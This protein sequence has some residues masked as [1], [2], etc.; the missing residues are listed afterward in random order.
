VA[1][2]RSKILALEELAAVIAEH[3]AKSRRVVQCHGIFDLIH[4]GHVRHF[5]QAKREGDVLVVT[6]TPDRYVNKGPDRPVFNE[7]LRSETIAALACVDYVAVNNWPTAV[8]TIHLLKPDVYAKGEEYEAPGNDVTGMIFE[9]ER[10]ILEEGGRIHFTHEVTFSSSHLLNAHFDVFT[11]DAS[12]FLNAFRQR[13]SADDV[14]DLLTSFQALKVLVVGDAIVDEYVFCRAY[15]MAS[16]STSIAAQFQS[17]ERHAGGAL[18]VANHLAGF[19]AEVEIVTCLGG[20]DSR[21]DWIRAHLKPNVVPTFHLRPDAPTTVKRRY[22][23]DFLV[24]KMFEV[25][26]FNDEPLPEDAEAAVERDLAAR[27]EAADVVVVADFGHGF[28]GPRTI[29]TV[30]GAARFLALN[31]QTNAINLGYNPV[32]RYPR[33]DYVCIGADEAHL[34]FGDRNAP[35]EEVLAALAPRLG[36]P[37]FAITRGRQG[38]IVRAKQGETAS[39]P[40][41]S[42][43]VVD[44][45]G[46][47]DAFLALTAPLAKLGCPPE[48]IGFVGNAVG[49]LAV[50]VVGNKESVEPI[51]LYRFISTLLK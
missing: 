3:K 26:Q 6:L 16:K 23:S 50:R 49:G 25:V 1:V 32:T 46:A 12:T 2:T 9:E 27:A 10:A 18:A 20:L 8:E 24:T 30:A 43:E 31:T 39:V 38:S 48:L 17:E 22:V 28:L 51:P 47:G 34:A 21:E 7:L 15:G 19:C 14:I 36:A 33:A 45:I 35:I 5:E 40:I 42:R 41:F 4:P 13:Y 11:P 29:E 37:V 44:T